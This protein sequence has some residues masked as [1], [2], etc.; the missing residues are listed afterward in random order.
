MP[1]DAEI[2]EDA[3]RRYPECSYGMVVNGLTP[4][5]QL[6]RVVRLWRNEECYFSDDPPRH[7]VEGY[8]A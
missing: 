6:T 3:I 4:F 1:T 7:E 5:L 2:I 8:P